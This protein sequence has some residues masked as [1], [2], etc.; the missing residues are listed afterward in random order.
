MNIDPT[1]FSAAAGMRFDQEQDMV[2]V[3]VIV[4]VYNVAQFIGRCAE[5]VFSQTLDEMEVIFVDDASP[6]NS[7]AI[8]ESVL[9]RYPGRKSQVRIVR[10]THNRGLP[11]ARNTGLGYASGEY[12]FHWDSDD[13]ADPDMLESLYRT[14]SEEGAD[15][16]WCDWYLTFAHN[17]RYMKQPSYG[18]PVEALKGMMSGS[19]KYNVWN[20]LARRRIYVEN[21]IAFPSGYGM[22]EDMTMMMLFACASKAVYLPE[23]FYHYVRTNVAAFTGGR[24][25]PEKF[26]ALKYNVQ[27]IEDFMHARYGNAMDMEIAFLKLDAKFPFLI[28][29][30][31]RCFYRMWTEWYPEADSYIMRNKNVSLRSRILQFCASKGQFWLVRLHYHV[32]CRFVYGIIYR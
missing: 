31:D 11:A 15:I 10:H 26:D 13:Y 22:G 3:S 4:P 12:V 18:S 20:K 27:R 5:S 28:F 7:I 8:L 2:K 21:C 6:D 25:T 9:E 24:A 19:M 32:V 14:A 23:A 16:V 30:P 17:E 29:R 1:G